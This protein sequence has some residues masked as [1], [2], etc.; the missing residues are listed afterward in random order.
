MSGTGA[1][2][3]AQPRRSNVPLIISLCLNVA[4]V[5]MIVVG[6]IQFMRLPFRPMTA[7]GPLSA[8]ALLTEVPPSEQPKIQAVIDA[9]EARLHELRLEAV[10]AR[11]A[12]FRIFEEPSFSTS[13]FAGALDRVEATTVAVQSEMLKETAE[14]VARLTPA[15]RQMIG[16]KI[17]MRARPMWRLFAPER[18][19][20]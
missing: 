15:E 5:A 8:Q 9:H 3:T 18:R 14:S 4:L 12:A 17:R 11:G 10:Q 16:Q 1:S 20:R 19:N 2:E 6:T 13:D 7:G